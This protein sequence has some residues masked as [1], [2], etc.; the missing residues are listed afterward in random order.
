MKNLVI[1]P[2]YNEKDNIEPIIKAIQ[3]Q[4]SEIHILVVDDGSP[5]GTGAIVRS[6]SESD[7]R[8]HL[9]ENSG[10]GGLGKAYL[11]GFAWGLENGFDACIQMD[12]DFS[13]RPVDLNKLVE[14]LK[15][16]DFVIGSRYVQ[17]GATSN[18]AWY[19]KMISLFGC[20]YSRMIL[21]Y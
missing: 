10:K 15:S 14:A 16:E 2:T 8:I 9:L 11:Q 3:E 5:D 18:W 21:G 17:G 20:F 4:Q 13:H 6:L 1:I 19:R 12:A 7:Q